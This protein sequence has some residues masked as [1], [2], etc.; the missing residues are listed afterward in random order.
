MYVIC[1]IK[2]DKYLFVACILS[3]IYCNLS[4]GCLCYRM[5]TKEKINKHCLL[6]QFSIFIN[7]TRQDVIK[8]KVLLSYIPN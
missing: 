7:R 6:L 2:F 1:Y 4:P 5:C 3:V 8:V